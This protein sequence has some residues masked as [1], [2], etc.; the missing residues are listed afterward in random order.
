LGLNAL[1]KPFDYIRLN[2][3]L[4]L[5]ATKTATDQLAKAGG[6]SLR[7]VKTERVED[8]YMVW[9]EATDTTGRAVTNVG[10]VTVGNLKGD[11][12]ANAMMKALTKAYRRTTLSFVGLGW[13]DE[14][15]I[16]T[17]RGAQTVVVAA[18]G[19]I[20]D[21]IPPADAARRAALL[22]TIAEAA[23]SLLIAPAQLHKDASKKDGVESYYDASIPYLE[24]LAKRLT[25]QVAASAKA[26]ATDNAPKEE[27]SL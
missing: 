14:T 21:G 25:D 11:A 19:E 1:T 5:Y 24:A 20:I 2:G 4:T 8:I 23:H 27:S 18:T 17:I 7:M 10:A 6:L 16:E 15:E 9:A 3:Q 22:A 12:L 26:A 13:L